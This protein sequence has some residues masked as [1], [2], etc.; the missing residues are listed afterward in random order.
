MT[1]KYILKPGKHQFAP[2]SHAVHTNDNLTDEATEWYLE[3]YPHIVQ[4]FIEK[5]EGSKDD[6]VKNKILEHPETETTAVNDGS[7]K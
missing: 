2:G 4:L 1:K 6:K 5:R 7:L 3:K